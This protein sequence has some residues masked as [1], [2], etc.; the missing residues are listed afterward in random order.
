[1]D[2]EMQ[3]LL[4]RPA[5]KAS[6]DD[7]L[8]ELPRNPGLYARN[9]YGHE[10]YKHAEHWLSVHVRRTASGWNEYHPS[11]VFGICSHPGHHACLKQY[12]A[13]GNL[14]FSDPVPGV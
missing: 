2:S 7:Q 13:D 10:I 3:A 8:V 11:G 6:F 1:M 12:A 9:R 4:K 5:T 14:Q